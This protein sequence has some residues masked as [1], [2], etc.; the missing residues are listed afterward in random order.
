MSGNQ[1]RIKPLIAS[2]VDHE[3]T[4]DADEPKTKEVKR[5]AKSISHR[6][7]GRSM[8]DPFAG[9]VRNQ[10]GGIPATGAEAEARRPKADSSGGKRPMG[11][12][13]RALWGGRV[14]RGVPRAPGAPGRDHSGWFP[15]TRGG[16]HDSQVFGDRH[17]R[18]NR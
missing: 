11:K 16:G 10:G 8:M 4:R 2:L 9:R 18:R 5:A 13:E 17:P 15:G 12:P 14:S 3:P 6:K 7:V 1:Q